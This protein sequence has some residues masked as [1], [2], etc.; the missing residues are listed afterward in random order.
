MSNI[1]YQPYYYKKP[2]PKSPRKSRGQILLVMIVMIVFCLT[3][4]YVYKPIDSINE[5]REYYAVYSDMVEDISTANSLSSMVKARGG[6]G[7]VYKCSEGYAIF[8]SIY[9]SL[10]NAQQVA[11]S[12]STT[13]ANAGV[14]TL[15]TRQNISRDVLNILSSSHEAYLT[16]YEMSNQA[17]SHSLLEE[18]ALSQVLSIINNFEKRYGELGALSSDDQ[19]YVIAVTDNQLAYLNDLAKDSAK[20]SK[21]RYCYSAMICSQL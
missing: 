8:T 13:D 18:Q 7:Y 15:R 3:V 19:T 2:T 5:Y 12:L 20:S 16:L 10:D 21:I 11:N 6:A 9:T 1:D 14:Y 4:L 17:D